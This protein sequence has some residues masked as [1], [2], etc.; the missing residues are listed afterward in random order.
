MLVSTQ[1]VGLT[2]AAL[3]AFFAATPAGAQALT[4]HYWLEAAAYW[5]NVDTE[6]QISSVTNSTIGTVIDLEQDLDLDDRK[7]LPSVSAGARLGSGFSIG[8]DYY[9]LGRN[10]SVAI[11]RDII[12]DDV[13]YPTNAVIES[14]FNT[15]I[16]RFTVGYAFARGPNYEVGGAIGLHATDFEVSLSGQGTIAGNPVASTQTR[17]RSALA[18]LPT[19]GLFGTWEVAPRVTIGGRIDYLSLSIGDYDGRLINTQ[20]TIAYRLWENVGIGLMYRYVDYRLD[21]EKND[22]LGRIQYKFNGPAIFLQL[23]F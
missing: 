18:P 5:P 23:G 20:A 13:T 17:R 7:V 3:G 14:E 11:S 2:V 16:Y 15:D 1:R 22:Y 12:F 19:V 21:V 9:S 4:D 6:V 8:F 10:G